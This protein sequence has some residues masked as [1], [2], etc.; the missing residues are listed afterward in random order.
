MENESIKV[1]IRI[2]REIKRFYEDFSKE[3]GAPQSA[4]MAL[5]LKEYM[6]QKNAMRDLPLLLNR[7]NQMQ[8]ESG[9]ISE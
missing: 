2:S 3:V 9:G 1:N 4:L 7:L 8:N 6:D 5:A